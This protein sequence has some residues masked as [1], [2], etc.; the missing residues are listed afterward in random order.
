[1][2]WKKEPKTKDYAL[3]L[4]NLYTA[5]YENRDNPYPYGPL[6]QYV[7]LHEYDLVND[8][9]EDFLKSTRKREDSPLLSRRDGN[10]ASIVSL[11]SRKKITYPRDTNQRFFIIAHL[12]G[13]RPTTLNIQDKIAAIFNDNKKLTKGLRSLRNGFY[14]DL[15]DWKYIRDTNGHCRFLKVTDA[16]ERNRISE[17]IAECNYF[18]IHE[19]C[20]DKDGLKSILNA[21]IKHMLE[22][23]ER[24]SKAIPKLNNLYDEHQEVLIRFC[25]ELNTLL[26]A[27][28]DS[29]DE[30]EK[31]RLLGRV[32]AWLLIGAMLRESFS[33]ELMDKCLMPNLP[34]HDTVGSLEPSPRCQVEGDSPA[35]ALKKHAEQSD[36]DVLDYL[37]VRQLAPDLFVN[38]KTGCLAGDFRSALKGSDEK[39]NS[40]PVL[41][42]GRE[43][44]AP[45]LLRLLSVLVQG[46]GAVVEWKDIFWRG[47]L[48]SKWREKYAGHESIASGSEEQLSL[49]PQWNPTKKEIETIST[50]SII[51][52]QEAINKARKV[53]DL[54][55]KTGKSEQSEIITQDTIESELSE[56]IAKKTDINESCRNEMILRAETGKGY[57]INLIQGKP[58]AQQGLDYCHN[59]LFS[60][61]K[62]C[63]GYTEYEDF[64]LLNDEIEEKGR[65]RCREVS[66]W[67][68]RYY[69]RTCRFFENR[70]SNKGNAD[71]DSSE[72]EIFGNYKMVQA[73]MIPY[74]TVGNGSHEN[75][76]RTMLDY[77]ELWH[78]QAGNPGRVL[79]LHGQPGDGKTTFCRKAVY[80][81]CKEGWLQGSPHVFQFSLNPVDSDIVKNNKINFE[82]AF[83]I[84]EDDDMRFTLSLSEL[85]NMQKDERREDYLCGS[86]I[87]LDGYDELAGSLGNDAGTIT[88]ND[89]YDKAKIFAENNKCNVIITSRTMCIEADLKGE[90]FRYY[91]KAPVAAFAPLTD[92][93]QD[94]MI[95]RMIELDMLRECHNDGQSDDYELGTTQ[96]NHG[97]SKESVTSLEDYK[98]VLQDLRK[99]S[100]KKLEDFKELLKVPILFRMI[101]QKRFNRF[102]EADTVAELY[103]CL[104]YD[105]LSQKSYEGAEKLSN[106]L[107]KK[108]EEIALRI[109]NYDKD[110]C[111]FTSGIT[112]VE[113]D[114]NSDREKLVYYFYTKRGGKGVEYLGFLHNSFYQYF[115]AR[116]IISSVRKLGIQMLGEK[117]CAESESGQAGN[118]SLPEDFVKLFVSLRADKLADP[119]MWKLVTQLARIEQG[120]RN[121]SPGNKCLLSHTWENRIRIDHVRCVLEC[122]DQNNLF[123]DLMLAKDPYERKTEKEWEWKNHRYKEM[124][125]AVFNLLSSC[126]AIE[127]GCIEGIDQNEDVSF[128]VNPKE[129]GRIEYGGINGYPNISELL[130][131]GDYSN[132]YLNGINLANCDLEYARLSYAYLVGTIMNRTSLYRA[133]LKGAQMDG[134]NLRNAD[135]MSADLSSAVL[136]NAQLEEAKLIKA[137][138]QNAVLNNARMNRAELL[139]ANMESAVL[140]DACLKEARMEYAHLG[141]ARLNRAHLEGASLCGAIM[142]EAILE[143]AHLEGADLKEAHLKE[144]VLA[145]SYLTNTNMERAHLERACMENAVLNGTNLTNAFM[146]ESYLVGAEV[147]E[148]A[149]KSM[150]GTDLRGVVFDIGQIEQSRAYHIPDLVIRTAA[151]DR[152]AITDFIRKTIGLKKGI[153]EGER[154][155]F[156]KYPQ[157]TKA[158]DGK[159]IPEP[160]CWRVLHVDEK[161][162]RALLITEKLIDCRLY[163]DLRENVSWEQCSLR[164]WIN[165][166][167]IRKAFTTEEALL[168]SGGWND[169]Q[170]NMK[171]ELS[172]NG[173]YDRAFVLS[174]HEAKTYFN[175]DGDRQAVVT[176]YARK[177]GSDAN[178]ERKEGSGGNGWW[179]LRSSGYIARSAARVFRSGN[180]SERGNHVDYAS[181]SVRPALWVYL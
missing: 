133:I 112:G 111:P 125:N 4:N 65:K 176:N 9:T 14:N 175:N 22:A 118:K 53:I 68:R 147:D 146:R 136:E 173:T 131:R 40:L 99:S 23:E 143:A 92:E 60:G 153:T 80:A 161:K 88:F 29:K 6:F 110:T 107:V 71:V 123:S 134:T 58:E 63:K 159:Y 166:D 15:L 151:E 78:S 57:R 33:N 149:F 7:N 74:A 10:Y 117:K 49:M 55:Q 47:R 162:H 158:E 100:N 171:A 141:C 16:S 160:L 177:E 37:S 67:L 42:E 114:S 104:F 48:I 91:E 30:E 81:H 152:R 31:D 168:I 144:A 11:Y 8:H 179:W 138:L 56:D 167:F 46:E 59:Y 120:K 129:K 1:M 86:L 165:G 73:Y 115:L 77:V 17:Y 25:T 97:T 169:N 38:W 3:L 135:M 64:R 27:F 24:R 154:I 18:L 84:R 127:N 119:D 54:L 116:R 156:G 113:E 83:C 90:K 26:I 2:P 126:A 20:H 108:Y 66:A 85:K 50:A 178:Y 139:Q 51:E 105:L 164:K 101:V 44:N 5:L 109:F 89:F 41:D 12:A 75:D 32:L 172:S 121:H 13:W 148:R 72:N 94:A 61:Y 163:H 155:L 95:D 180:I 35:T 45:S 170:E 98:K 132:I 28:D 43:L 106:R 34:E 36:I 140:E 96:K 174:I 103:G 122:L 102:E 181:G 87:I 76:L 150:S 137:N 130:R 52:L 124:E 157:E 82:N 62:D 70:V 19:Y 128:G 79:V 142:D 69:H 93:Q 21:F 145:G 39:G